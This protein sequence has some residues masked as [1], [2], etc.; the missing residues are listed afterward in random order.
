MSKRT[1]EIYRN[2]QKVENTKQNDTSKKTFPTKHHVASKNKMENGGKFWEDTPTTTP[3]I[4]L[5]RQKF[6]IWCCLMVT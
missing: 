1:P 2:D 5:W 3:G 4:A 6:K